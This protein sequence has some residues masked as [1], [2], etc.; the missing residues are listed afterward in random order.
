MPENAA[1]P[2]ARRAV[3]AVWRIESAKI[4]AALTRIVGDLD[5]AEDLAG[6]ALLEAVEQWPARGAPA[7]PPPG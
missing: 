5:L 1:E 4:V 2:A 6:Q 7:I 3:E